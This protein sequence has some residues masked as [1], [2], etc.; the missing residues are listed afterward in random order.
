MEK[1]ALALRGAREEAH[2]PS[3]FLVA[4]VL[5]AFPASDS[6]SPPPLLLA[7]DVVVPVFLALWLWR[8]EGIKEDDGGK[9]PS[10]KEVS[11]SS[12]PRPPPAAEP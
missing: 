11:S 4:A 6:S 7:A 5:F 2:A 1:A 10:S 3:A 12:P 8:S 9:G